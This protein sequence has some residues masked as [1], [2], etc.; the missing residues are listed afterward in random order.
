M[1]FNFD[2][3]NAIREKNC[4]QIKALLSQGVIVDL[5]DPWEFSPLHEAADTGCQ[6]I[7]VLLLDNE[8][9]IDHQNQ[10]EETPL[11]TAVYAEQEII[12]GLLLSRGANLI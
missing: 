12:V 5:N 11:H 9:C 6:A 4:T 7:F 3:Q 10:Y 8:L 1:S 2:L